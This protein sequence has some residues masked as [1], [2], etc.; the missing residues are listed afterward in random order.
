MITSDKID[1]WIKEAEQRP[2]S[3]MTILKL[4]AGRLRDLSERNEELLNE[5]IALQDGSRVEEYQKRIAHLEY[6]LDLL[7]RSGV[8]TP[9][10]GQPVDV[11]Q[12]ICLLAYNS[13]GRILRFELAADTTLPSID[14]NPDQDPPRLLAI[15][16]QED[17]LLLFTTGRIATCP[18]VHIPPV[19]G[20]DAWDQGALPDEPH[21]GEQ[22]A[23]LLPV[24]RLPLADYFVQ[25]SRKGCI[26]KT[27]TSMAQT[28]LTNHYL[29]R[30][31]LQKADQ[32]FETLLCQKG[33]TL[34]LVSSEGR[35][36][37][38][39]VDALPY[40]AEE[41]IRLGIGDHLVASFAIRPEHSLLCVTQAGKLLVREVDSLDPPKSHLAQG[42]ALIS[43]ERLER[44]IRFVGALAVKEDDRV[45]VL[46]AGGTLSLHTPG[47][48]A[49]AGSVRSEEPVLSIGLIPAGK[50]SAA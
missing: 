12:A 31:T 1:E 16:P 32:P 5:N 23:C 29:G 47:E 45:A 10:G 8:T 3:A 24:A 30:G 49:G 15:S 7:K 18:V 50:G 40:A 20:H 43:P 34:A 35:V 17:V 27:M 28:V 19:E 6:Q 41:R 39:D 48:L 37:R 36:M 33:D 44:G 13:H 38:L 42:Q 4:I 14:I 2:G 46:N 11:S 22:L 21:A 26:K 9:D 25:A